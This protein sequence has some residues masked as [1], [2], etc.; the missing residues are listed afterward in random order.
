LIMRDMEKPRDSFI[1]IR[2][3]YDKPGEQVYRNTPVDLPALANAGA[4]TRLDLAR[5]LVAQ[6]NPLTARVTVN[7]LWQQFFGYGIV[8][9]SA[10]FG[11]Q[12]E[13]PTHPELLDWLGGAFGSPKANP[14]SP[15]LDFQAS[16][17]WDVKA[18][19]RLMVT[20]ETYR[21][22]SAASE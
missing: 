7:R 20:S 8:K 13:T 14:A 10:D 5:W 18:L 3:Q 6:E 22:T 16:L 9:T 15:K 4:P 17:G 19:V 2:G 21:Q 11:S 1:M 12:G